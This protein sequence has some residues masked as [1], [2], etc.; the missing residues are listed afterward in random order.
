VRICIHGGACNDR[1]FMLE[2]L[3]LGN[4]LPH[5]LIYEDE[6]LETHNTILTL[7]CS[8][9]VLQSHDYGLLLSDYESG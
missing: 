3:K 1:N 8:G 6:C 2:I 7:V 4:M 5:L 9:I